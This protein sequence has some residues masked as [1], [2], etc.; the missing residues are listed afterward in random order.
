[1]TQNFDGSPMK[2]VLCVKCARGYRAEKN[3]CV[4]CESCVCAKNEIVLLGRCIP[5]KFVTERP[6]YE[7]NKINPIVMLDIV[8]YEYLCTVSYFK[9]N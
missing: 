3:L 4:R 9:I 5:K 2:E 7:E 8:K 6:K 1:M